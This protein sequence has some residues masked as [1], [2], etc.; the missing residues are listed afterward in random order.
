LGADCA[1]RANANIVCR[2][3]RRGF[4]FVFAITVRA[5]VGPIAAPDVQEGAARK[6][7]RTLP[8]KLLA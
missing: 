6:W 4:K 5:G 2:G 8:D 1:K 7:R 3:S